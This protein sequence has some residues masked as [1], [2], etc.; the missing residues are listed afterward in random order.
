MKKVTS[1][2]PFTFR[3]D[4]ATTVDV[5]PEGTL[6]ADN[7]AKALSER[8]GGVV[9]VENADVVGTALEFVE[10]LS[11]ASFDIKDDLTDEVEVAEV[12]GESDEVEVAEEP[13]A[14]KARGAK[15]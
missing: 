7:V 11:A 9:R 12:D 15:K 1:K 14:K 2:F 13:V 5:S 4:G 6:C 3:F 8:Y 10:S